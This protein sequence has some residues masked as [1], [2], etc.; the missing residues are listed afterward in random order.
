MPSHRA[1]NLQRRPAGLPA[2]GG[3]VRPAQWAQAP[4]HPK[5]DSGAGS[6]LPNKRRSARTEQRGQV[7]RGEQGGGEPGADR[8][9][10]RFAVVDD[11]TGFD[12]AETSY[13]TGVQ[14]MADRLD[15][16]G[17]ALQVVSPKAEARP[18]KAGS[19]HPRA[20]MPDRPGEE[21]GPSPARPRLGI[22]RNRV[23]TLLYPV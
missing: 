16:I 4:P 19:R 23:Q 22:Y 17:G 13:G 10:L 2:P 9:A 7:R 14:G 18:S 11:G 12:T 8:W 21:L 6:A 1:S 20:Q 5:E 15:A 3:P